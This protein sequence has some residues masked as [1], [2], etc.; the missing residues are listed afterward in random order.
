[1]SRYVSINNY[2]CAYIIIIIILCS[3][4]TNPKNENHRVLRLLEQTNYERTMDDFCTKHRE[5]LVDYCFDDHEPICHVCSHY[6][7][8]KRHTVKPLKEILVEQEER[9]K[10][11]RE[12]LSEVIKSIEIGFFK[13]NLE[14]LQA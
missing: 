14:S 5:R 3:H 7:N 8:H 11:T 6:E 2:H 9:I 13:M 12:R 10:E 1:M 4:F